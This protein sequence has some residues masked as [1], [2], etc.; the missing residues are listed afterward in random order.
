MIILAE[1]EG[2]SFAAPGWSRR[3]NISTVSFPA[4]T[5]AVFRRQTLGKGGKSVKH[6]AA[7]ANTQRR[8]GG[9][10]FGFCPPFPFPP[11]NRQQ[12]EKTKVNQQEKI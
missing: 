5:A 9:K 1:E 4:L 6:F 3:V 7:L 2:K 10:K 12:I 11:Q 8:G